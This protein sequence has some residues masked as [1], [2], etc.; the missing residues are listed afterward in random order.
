MKNSFLIQSLA[1]IAILG[2]LAAVAT[3]LWVTY[4]LDTPL[5][6]IAVT[7]SPNQT[8]YVA[9]GKLIFKLNGK[10]KLLEQIPFSRLGTFETVTDISAP[11]DNELLV[12][13][14]GWGTVFRCDLTTEHCQPALLKQ[15]KKTNI[16]FGAIRVAQSP[17]NAWLYVADIAQ[18]LIDRYDSNGHYQDTLTGEQTDLLYPNDLW[19]TETGLLAITD[20]NHHRIV[21]FDTESSNFTQPVLEFLVKGDFEPTGQ[22]GI[23]APETFEQ[24]ARVWPIGVAQAFNQDWWVVNG[25]GNFF[26]N[27]VV[28]FSPEGEELRRISIENSEPE[29]ISLAPSENA[30]I[31][32]DQ[33][34]LQVLSAPYEGQEIS[35][36]GDAAFQAALTTLQI[37]HQSWMKL[38]ET[39][40]GV[41]AIFVC[42][43]IIVVYLEQRHK[44]AQKFSSPQITP[45]ATKPSSI[46]NSFISDRR[47]LMEQAEIRWIYPNQKLI[48]TLFFLITVFLFLGIP[49]F[50]NE[51][52]SITLIPKE[53]YFMIGTVVPTWLILLYLSYINTQTGIGT[54]GSHIWLFDHQRHVLQKSPTEI[55]YSREVLISGDVVVQ[56]K[57][58]F[59]LPLYPSEEIQQHILPLLSP[60]NQK[61]ILQTQW[62]LLKQGHFSLI[63][64]LLLTVIVTTLGVL[65]IFYRFFA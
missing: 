13:D 8:L 5:G 34:N 16:Y 7:N 60:N 64:Q 43:A 52:L 42:L 39:A 40:W 11:K 55:I 12:T 62:Q 6:P 59:N 65:M 4:Y 50:D 63:L 27:D 31:I 1:T 25:D 51:T 17:K 9:T 26:Y 44:N 33:R 19:I 14:S 41:L 20:T 54:D 21:G 35:N 28:V 30:M 2:I 36:F 22:A 18:H 45:Q 32:V 29:P 23:F 15:G 53:K 37:E 47:S 49:T 46:S 48:W 57:G 38:R 3:S 58:I 61:N 24:K 10:G 56:L